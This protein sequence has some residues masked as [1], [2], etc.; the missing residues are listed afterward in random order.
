MEE[1]DINDLRGR[2]GNHLTFSDISPDLG[3]RMAQALDPATI[4]EIIT[5]SGLRGRGGAGF[6]TGVKW[7]LTREQ[8]ANPKYIVCNAD[9][10][11]PG[12]FKDRLILTDYFNLVCQG[13]AIAGKAVGAQEGIV[14]LR[15]EYA[16]MIPHLEDVLEQRRKAGWLGKTILGDADFSFDITI[17]SGMGAYICGEETALLESLEGRRGEVRNR[18]PFPVQEGYKN[19]PTVINNVETFAWVPTIFEKGI[20]WFSTTGTP[21]SCGVR[22][23]SISGDCER[24]GVYEYPFGTPLRDVL[25]AAGA[26]NPK[27]AQVGGASGICVPAK[28]FD[29]PLAFEDLATGGSII[30]FGPQR[31]MF[32]V[33]ENFQKFFAEE[34]CGQCVPC[35]VGNMRL[36]QA[37]ETMRDQGLDAHTEQ[38]LR[39]LATTMRVASKCGL[40]QSSP[41]AFLSILEHFA[42]DLPRKRS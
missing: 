38:G 14:Y 36:A 26:K 33:A 12:T 7:K 41:N 39:Q 13:M 19:L 10:G 30:V 1:K 28:D 42:S 6:P 5:R 40:G 27:A 8:A 24:P 32:E 21:K 16:Y 25:K 3:L 9:E 23:F 37:I 11:E 31:D 4:I 35:R 22:L 2:V 29:R 15:A 17:R 18:F 20:V 34:S